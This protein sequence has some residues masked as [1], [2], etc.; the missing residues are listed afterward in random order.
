MGT[1]APSPEVSPENEAPAA[2]VTKTPETSSGDG[3][4]ETDAT[5]ISEEPE[6]PAMTYLDSFKVGGEGLE[7]SVNFLNGLATDG[8][9]AFVS[10]F[11][12]ITKAD[13]VRCHVPEKAGDSCLTCHNYHIQ[14]AAH[15]TGIRSLNALIAEPAA[16]TEMAPA[17][18]V[19]TNEP[20]PA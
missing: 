5:T 3:S 11:E 10:N 14:P 9:T 12:P 4:T 18:E 17:E 20:P 19:S 15:T 7:I 13:C 1:A 8:R 2:E 6:K 16:Q